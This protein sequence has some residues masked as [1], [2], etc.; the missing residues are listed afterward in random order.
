MQLVACTKL[1]HLFK[2][3]FQM[4]VMNRSFAKIMVRNL[5]FNFLK[6]FNNTK[7]E[8][9]AGEKVMVDAM[10]EAKANIENE[11]INKDNGQ[12]TSLLPKVRD[13]KNVSYFNN[14]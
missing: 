1:M 14:T 5:E 13:G 11:G 8:I 3:D 12:L 2:K 7:I 10:S 6:M 4:C 9:E